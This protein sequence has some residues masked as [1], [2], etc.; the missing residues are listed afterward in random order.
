[1]METVLKSISSAAIAALS[2]TCVAETAFADGEREG[3]FWDDP[4]TEAALAVSA[5]PDHVADN[6]TVWVLS[7]EAGEFVVFKEGTNG[8]NCAVIRRWGS[9]YGS[10]PFES[11]VVQTPNCF[12]A[13][14]SKTHF[15]EMKLRHKLGLEGKSSEEI[16]QAVFNAYGDGLIPTPIQTSFGYMMSNEQC[17]L[18]STKG[19]CVHGQ[20]HVMVYAPTNTNEKFGGS[21]PGTGLP[22]VLEQPNTWMAVTIIP[23]PNWQ[24][25]DW[26]E[27]K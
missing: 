2:V 13:Y 12:D 19:E 3:Q 22:F 25:V 26:N 6:A 16:K 20:P 14:A 10:P 15:E 17:L 5:G 4:R 27:F 24:E 11:D 21:Y 23:V 7:E 9:P 1:M 8:Y 18:E